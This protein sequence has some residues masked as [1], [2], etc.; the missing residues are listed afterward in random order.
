MG[1]KIKCALIGSGNIESVK[2]FHADGVVFPPMKESPPTMLDVTRLYR[3][4]ERSPILGEFF[5]GAGGV[6]GGER[7]GGGAVDV[8]SAL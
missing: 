8:V 2:R 4:K 6:S 3:K 7:G 5:G 1:R